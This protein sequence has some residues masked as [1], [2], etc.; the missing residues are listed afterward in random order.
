M[1]LG[2]ITWMSTPVASISLSRSV[3]SVMRLY[4]GSGTPPGPATARE[5]CDWS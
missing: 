2:L 5:Y 4:N 3:V 1:M